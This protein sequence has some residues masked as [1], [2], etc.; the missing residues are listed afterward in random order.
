VKTLRFTPRICRKQKNSTASLNTLYIA[1]SAQFYSAFSPTTISLTPRF[2]KNAQFD[3]AFLPKTLKMIRKCTVT[4]TA[5]YLTSRF[6]RQ[7]SAMLR[8]FSEKGELSKTLN[9]CANF[10]NFFEN[11]GRTAFCI[12]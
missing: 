3:S 5:L 2:A 9:I 11:D 6:W 10:K 4:K 8:A 12:Y 7:R 1:E